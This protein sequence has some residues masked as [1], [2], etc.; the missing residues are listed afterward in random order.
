LGKTQHRDENSHRIFDNSVSGVGFV[1][2]ESSRNC[3]LLKPRISGRFNPTESRSLS[4]EKSYSRGVETGAPYRDHSTAVS[5][6]SLPSRV[7]NWR[8]HGRWR[9]SSRTLSIAQ[10][11]HNSTLVTFP[12]PASSNGACG[13]P[14]LRF[15]VGFTPRVMRPFRLGVLSTS[16]QHAALG[17]G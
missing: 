4:S 11:G 2:L 6:I 3:L 14:A 8:A 1:G 10:W 12:A 7:E 9:V 16:V 15:P 13:F 5:P 17:S